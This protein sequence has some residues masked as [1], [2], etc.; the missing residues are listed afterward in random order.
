MESFI[1]STTLFIISI[2]VFTSE[3]QEIISLH[4]GIF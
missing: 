3:G 2:S 1:L 4:T